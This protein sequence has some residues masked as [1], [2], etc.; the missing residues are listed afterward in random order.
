LCAQVAVDIS[1]QLKPGLHEQQK[2]DPLVRAKK[3]RKIPYGP[4]FKNVSFLCSSK[5]GFKS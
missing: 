5:L 3:D 2:M 1:I 4:F